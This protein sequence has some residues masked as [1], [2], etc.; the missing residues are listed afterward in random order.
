MSAS[1]NIPTLEICPEAVHFQPEAVAVS[2]RRLPLAAK[3]SVA[4]LLLALAA[5]A[6]WAFWAEVDRIVAAEGRLVTTARPMVVRSMTQGVLT[7]MDVELGEV[8][9]QGQVLAKLDPTFS[10]AERDAVRERLEYLEALINRLEAELSGESYAPASTEEEVVQQRQVFARLAEERAARRESLE[11]Q[12]AMLKEK[13][14]AARARRERMRKQ[15]EIAA[16]VEAM[17]RGLFQKRMDSRLA[18]LEARQRRQ[19][20]ESELESAAEEARQVSESLAQARSELAS[21]AGG[22]QAEAAS[23]LA[24]ARQERAGLMHKL[25][26]ADRTSELAILRAGCDA[27]VQSVGDFAPGA[28]LGQGEPLVTLVPLDSPLEAE[29]K[30]QAK[31]IGRL[32]E[33]D[34]ARI[35]LTAFP[36]Q[37]HGVVVGALR[38]V[39]PDA[40]MSQVG[41]KQEAFYQGRL[42]LEATELRN[43]PRGFRLL[44]GMTLRAEI[45]VGVRRVASYLLDPLIRGLDEALREP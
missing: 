7:E 43:T 1:R 40:A 4:V 2:Q 32:R 12:A 26:K 21:W 30:I 19:A 35:K 6:V 11:H 3:A 29:V 17:R 42:A 34:A 9:R 39:S 5:A 38:V 8:V 20:L 23:K 44:P 36:F 22:V 16:E 25:A 24:E 37:Q 31:D 15:V 10:R 14:A 27:V 28:V 41:D 45:K 33:G 18:Y 13:L